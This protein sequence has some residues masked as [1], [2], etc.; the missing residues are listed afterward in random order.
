M[1]GRNYQYLAFTR[2]GVVM[3]PG[4]GQNDFSTDG[5]RV[6]YGQLVWMIDGLIDSNLYLVGSPSLVGGAQLGR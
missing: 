4:E 6:Q 1:N 3:S 5:I 2:P